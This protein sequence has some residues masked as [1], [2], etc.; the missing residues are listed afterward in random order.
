MSQ[1]TI[2]FTMTLHSGS[3]A[4]STD[5]AEQTPTL[6]TS[7]FS[8]FQNSPR[9]VKPASDRVTRTN[10]VTKPKRSKR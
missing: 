7:S 5:K 6:W 8:P 4:T 2:A 3:T 10:K 1:Q 9:S